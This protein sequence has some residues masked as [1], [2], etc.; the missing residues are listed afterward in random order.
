MSTQAQITANQANA[1]LSTGPRTEEGKAASSGNRVRY[2][3]TG[4]FRVLP[5]EDQDDFD[6][7]LMNLHAQHEPQTD[8][9][10]ELVAKMAQHYWLSQRAVFLQQRCFDRDLPVCADERQLALLLRY[11]TTHER[12]FERCT[13][14]LRKIRNQRRKDRIGFESQKQKAAQEARREA[15][16]K[17]RQERHSLDLLLAEAKITHVQ[18]QT[19]ALEFERI[20]HELAQKAA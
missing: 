18:R 3:L 19:S 12:A 1:Q 16:E 5:W 7:L 8:F 14:E 13:A 20:K 6:R 2:G 11:Q 10:I 4:R 9:E 17:R 15:S